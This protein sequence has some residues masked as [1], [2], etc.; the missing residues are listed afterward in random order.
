[1]TAWGDLEGIQF[2]VLTDEQIRSL[3]VVEVTESTLHTK[4]QPKANGPIDTRFGTCSR[5]QLCGTCK[6]SVQN[7]PGHPGF[8]ALPYPMPHVAFIKYLTQF[9]NVFCFNCSHFLLPPES[10][11]S[12]ARTA[13]NRLMFAFEE[14]RKARGRKRTPLM[15]RN[16]ECGVPQP[17]VYVEEPFIKLAWRDDV[18]QHFYNLEPDASLPQPVLSVKAQKKRKK[19]EEEEALKPAETPEQQVLRAQLQADYEYF[20]KRPFTNWDAYRVL[21]S[22]R[23]SDLAILGIDG[24]KTHPSGFM[25]LSIIVPPMGVRPTVSFEEGSKRCGYNQLTKKISEIVK[26][27]RSLLIEAADCKVRLD[28]EFAAEFPES[29]KTAIQMLYVTIA[30]YLIKDKCKVPGLKMS[31]Y[32]A[33]AHARAQS[34]SAALNGKK[35]R[36]RDTLMGKRVDF[37]L[38]TVVTTD[39]DADLDEIGLPEELAKRLT[40]PI[41]VNRHNRE[42]LQLLMSRNGVL[43]IVDEQ[44]GDMIAV[45][46]HNRD[47]LAL[48]DGWVVERFVRDGDWIPINRQPTLHRPSIMGHRVRIHKNRTLQLPAPCTIP[49]N[50]DHD[51]DEMNG[52]IPQTPEARAEVQEL[53]AVSRHIMHP[54]ANKPVMGIIQDGIDGSYFMTHVDTF[55]TR[56]EVMQLLM[57]IRYS[58]DA[59]INASLGEAG[60]ELQHVALPVPAILKPVARWTGKQVI[61]HLLLHL[62]PH[63]R[64][65]SM[66]AGTKTPASAWSAA[67]GRGKPEPEDATVIVRRGELLQGV[68]DKAAFGASEFGLV[69]CVHELLGGEATGR[70]LTQLGKLFTGFNQMVGFTC[71]IADLLLNP[72][73]DEARLALHVKADDLGLAGVR[74]FVGAEALDAGIPRA[75]L[76]RKV[77]ATD[78]HRLPLIA[79]DRARSSTGRWAS[80]FGWPVGRRRAPSLTGR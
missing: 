61:S 32:A 77:G 38:R 17:T 57:T 55:L 12:T 13:K 3:A 15:C 34:V 56:G 52:H 51:G 54:R 29:V 74:A 16:P 69:H 26:M 35:G 11:P 22:I 65:L 20:V 7:C 31:P 21:Q 58:R 68:L 23:K 78:C 19:M 80:D 63:A 73:A 59:D 42:A 18:V 14:A 43:Q 45:S 76:N 49:Y 39:P 46:E 5:F 67:K 24:D 70:L 79:T 27:K 60:T 8:I 41:R 25:L 64:H 10:L 4:S 30:H 50:A 28:A 2:G 48:M 66:E 53:M 75:V 1:M 6:N 40:I 37:C 33:R 62:H 36:Y 9:M 47:T 71:G 72:E 44:S